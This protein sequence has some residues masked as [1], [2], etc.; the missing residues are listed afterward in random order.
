[1]FLSCFLYKFSWFPPSHTVMVTGC[2]YPAPVILTWVVSAWVVKGPFLYFSLI[3]SQNL[4][5]AHLSI[6]THIIMHTHIIITFRLRP[7]QPTTE[8]TR[9]ENLPKWPTYQVRNDQPPKFGWNNQRQINPE[10]KWPAFR[11][12]SQFNSQQV[13]IN[14]ALSKFHWTSFVSYNFCLLRCGFVIWIY[15]VKN[16]EPL[17]NGPAPLFPKR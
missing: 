14:E 1:M 12:I 17:V 6:H 5:P 8:M 7:K 2:F 4:T 16:L 10:P 15:W 13:P 11:S 9:S 3:F